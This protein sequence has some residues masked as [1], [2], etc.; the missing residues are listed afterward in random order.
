M[1]PC[2]VYTNTLES[3]YTAALVMYGA[4]K[5]RDTAEFFLRLPP[6]CYNLKKK[7]QFR[8]K[9]ISHYLRLEKDN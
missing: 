5:C 2:D 4:Q 3:H 9:L 8:A 6:H 7:I 1:T